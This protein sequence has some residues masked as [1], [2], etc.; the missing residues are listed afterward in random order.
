M[1]AEKTTKS[2]SKQILK[3]KKNNLFKCN[4]KCKRERKV[5]ESYKF[6]KDKQFEFE[7]AKKDLDT[8]N[9]G[10]RRTKK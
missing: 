4:Y 7:K 5:V 8:L 9:S 6:T 3:L 2:N 1:R 10:N